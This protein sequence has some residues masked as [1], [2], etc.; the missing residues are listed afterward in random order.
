[1]QFKGVQTV[2]YF[3]KVYKAGARFR[4]LFQ[5]MFEF[6]ISDS[7][8]KNNRFRFWHY[9]QK[10]RINAVFFKKCPSFSKIAKGSKIGTH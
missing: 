5:E 4:A 10:L 7:K 8:V 2:H 1:M 3:R 6:K 9:D